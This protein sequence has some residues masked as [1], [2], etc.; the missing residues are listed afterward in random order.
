MSFLDRI[1]E[2]NRHDPGLYAPFAIAGIQVGQVRRD[3]LPLLAECEGLI[4]EPEGVRLAPHLAGAAPRTAALNAA[5]RSLAARGFCSPWRDEAFAVGVQ[6]GDRMCDIDRAGT[7]L[8]GIT[9]HGI[10]VNGYVTNGQNLSLWVPRRAL[11]GTFPGQFDNITGGGQPAGISLTENLLKECA[12]E[13]GIPAELAAE[14]TPAGIVNYR[15]DTAVGLRR[16][17]LFVFDLA[18]PHSFTP[19]NRDGEVSDFRLWPAAEV[20]RRLADTTD[21][22]FDSALVMI[23]FFIRRGLITPDYPDYAALCTGL[24]R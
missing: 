10:H 21:I 12:E 18:V 2:C 14:A 13:A 3:R 7:E 17:V 19:E 15:L 20:M 23:D 16:A 1:R 8:F 6:F 11:D 4:V 24:R 22:K 9:A 5:V